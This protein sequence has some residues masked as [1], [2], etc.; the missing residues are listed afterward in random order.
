MKK[1]SFFEGL[2]VGQKDVE[3]TEEVFHKECRVLFIETRSNS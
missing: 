3:G 1:S 2:I